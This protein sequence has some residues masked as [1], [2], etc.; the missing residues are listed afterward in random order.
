M[1]TSRPR[2]RYHIHPDPQPSNTYIA[3]IYATSICS[4]NADRT[5]PRSLSLYYLDQD[6]Q[7]RATRRGVMVGKRR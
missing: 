1:C 5:P 4:A 3:A 2:G 6:A 7:H